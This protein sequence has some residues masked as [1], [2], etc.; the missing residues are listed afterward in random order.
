MSLLTSRKLQMLPFLTMLLT[1][2][3][4]T[5]DGGGIPQFASSGPHAEAYGEAQ[6]FPVGD[7]HT[8]SNASYLVGS[9]SH[10]DAIFPARG[11]PH[12]RSV[13]N[14][15]REGSEPA[16]SYEYGGRSNSIDDYLFHIPVTGLLIGKDDKILVE[17]YQY[18]RTD[19][20]R[21]T[22]ASM[23]K[24]MVAMLLGIASVDN[25]KFSIDRQAAAFVPGLRHSAYGETTLRDLLHMSSGV[26]ANDG[27][28]L[29]KL[30]AHRVSGDARVLAA[31]EGRPMKPGV[32]FH[33]SCGDSET[34]GLV[35]YNMA[36][37]SLAAYLSEKIWQP[38]GAEEDASWSIDTSGEE[39]T[40]FGL[41]ATLRD[42]GRV[43]RLLASDGLWNGRQIIPKRW[44]LEATTIQSSD[45]QLEPGRASQRFGYGYQ[46]WIL[47]GTRRMFALIGADGQFI[48]IDPTTKLFLV[49]TAVCISPFDAQTAETMRLWQSV[50]KEMGG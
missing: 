10:F 19:H 18:G 23:A 20:D 48:L 16:I 4:R 46:L 17:R 34:L 12:P 30:Y 42:W 38:I 6:N 26:T 44:L 39:V 45:S 22:S 14:F 28:L 35:L 11:V 9:Y 1:L 29:H 3:I 8:W 21:F 5:T 24:T 2:G 33:Y 40:C 37:K 32:R 50:V 47:P 15:R 43:A 36:G 31:F 49:Q 13:W 7:V 27:I 25:S 41:N